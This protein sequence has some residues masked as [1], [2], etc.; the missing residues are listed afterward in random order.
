MKDW[1]RKPYQSKL[2]YP[3]FIRGTPAR[4]LWNS[5]T[6]QNPVFSEYGS[7]GEKLTA[8]ESRYLKFLKQSEAKKPYLADDYQS[9]EY[10]WEGLPGLQDENPHIDHPWMPDPQ[11]T[12]ID[13]I[14]EPGY[15]VL[16]AFTNDEFCTARTKN[17]I[18][19]GTHP[20]YNIKFTWPGL[21]EPGTSFTIIDGI[22]TNTVEIALTAG[23][24]EIGLISMQAYEVAFDAPPLPSTQGKGWTAF[25]VNET[26]DYDYCGTFKFTLNLADG[27]P[28]TD[29][30]PGQVFGVKNS[31]SVNVPFTS[32]YDASQNEWTIIIPGHVPGSGE[33]YSFTYNANSPSVLTSYPFK[34]KT[35][36]IHVT[37]IPPGVYS[38][39][40]HWFK[41]ISYNWVNTSVPAICSGPSATGPIASGDMDYINDGRMSTHPD[42]IEREQVVQATVEYTVG[43][44]MAIN[45]A[46][47]RYKAPGFAGGGGEY[48]PSCGTTECMLPDSQWTL[49]YDPV[50][51]CQSP[52]GTPLVNF[53]GHIGE[54]PFSIR[55]TDTDGAWNDVYTGNAPDVCIG[56]V[57]NTWGT[58]N[59]R[60]WPWPPLGPV[61][62]KT[63]NVIGSMSG[64]SH[65]MKAAGEAWQD[66]YTYWCCKNGP[67]PGDYFTL[68]VTLQHIFWN[69]S[70]TGVIAIQAIIKY[71]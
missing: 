34:Y 55:V 25:T 37:K 19:H 35:A 8:A 17:I 33:T 22:G 49:C 13:T 39:T 65:I 6:E 38:D 43:Y 42:G 71:T 41:V 3:D 26:N 12:Q 45:D 9:M 56:Q 59:P 48:M 32:F 36:D 20:I 40:L 51:Y 66:P 29:I 30:L 54:P 11:P 18:V 24:G 2:S 21:V 47:F 70:T 63:A 60:G 27:S 28:Y 10:D 5:V 68:P 52:L 67:N 69:G 4:A 16:Y 64:K 31:L 58:V 15:W 23:V 57:V 46:V 7:N 1:S 61:V 44:S 53:P 14:V 62:V 50:F